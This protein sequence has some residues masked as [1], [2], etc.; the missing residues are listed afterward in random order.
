MPSFPDVPQHRAIRGRTILIVEDQIL[1]ADLAQDFLMDAGAGRVL[2][3]SD[4]QQALA[5]MQGS[6]QIDAAVVDIQLGGQSGYQLA[7]VL[8]QR[9]VP[10]IFATGYSVTAIPDSWRHIATLGK[11]YTAGMLLDSLGAAIAA[12]DGSP[13]QRRG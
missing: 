9:R 8:L 11:P 10:F 6:S 2:I 12:A 3:A 4:L 7:D 1:V 5:Q 13:D